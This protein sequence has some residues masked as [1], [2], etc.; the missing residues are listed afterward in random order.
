MCNENTK[1]AMISS[2]VRSVAIAGIIFPV[3]FSIADGINK[4]TDQIEDTTSLSA[5]LEQIKSDLVKNCVSWKVA[6][7]D[8]KVERQSETS[9]DE[10]FNG[11]VGHQ[12]V[13]NWVLN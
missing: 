9:I 7:K 1:S 11:S 13:C 3:T 10:Y 5:Q 6:N 12:Q 2:I 4:L 8:S